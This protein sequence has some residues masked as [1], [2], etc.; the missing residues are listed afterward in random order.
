MNAFL[1][2]RLV[3]EQTLE[4]NWVWARMPQP[5]L[6]GMAIAKA[7]IFRERQTIMRMCQDLLVRNKQGNT[8]EILTREG[9]PNTSDVIIFKCIVADNGECQAEAP[10][11]TCSECHVICCDLHGP[12]HTKHAYFATPEATQIHIRRNQQI[13]QGSLLSGRGFART[14]RGIVRGSRVGGRESARRGRNSAGHQN[15]II[16]RNSASQIRASSPESGDA[17]KNIGQMK[18]QEI[19]DELIQQH[20]VKLSY[21][22]KNFTTLEALK[23]MLREKRRI[24]EKTVVNNV[25]SESKDSTNEADE[26]SGDDDSESEAM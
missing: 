18:I 25:E 26:V 3:Q 4:Q 2:V 19:R 12:E 16:S 13:S 9:L 21:L 5:K 17:P 22:T 14:G 8:G 24:Q 15:Q 11:F 10:F 20:K 7:E 23:F 1:K 6:D